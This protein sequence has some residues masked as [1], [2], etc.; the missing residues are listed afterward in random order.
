MPIE[1]LQKYFNKWLSTGYDLFG[2]DRSGSAA[3]FYRWGFKG[4][5]DEATARSRPK[6]SKG[7]TK[8]HASSITKKTAQSSNR[9]ID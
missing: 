6:I 2:K 5:F 8:K 4:R 9:S 1:I 7:S 3:R